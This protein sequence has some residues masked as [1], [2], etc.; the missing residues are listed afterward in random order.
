M[1]KKPGRAKR[2]FRLLFALAVVLG[3]LGYWANTQ[4]QPTAPAA[5][6]HI[7]YDD[8]KSLKAVLQH[9]QQKG[10]V[11][12]A[13][14]A[15]LY[16]R[17]AKTPRQVKRGTYSVKPG[18][19]VDE[20]FKS[21]QNPIRQMVR[22]PETYWAS[23][24][25]PLLEEKGV[26]KA[27][28]YMKWVHSPQ[29]FQDQVSFPLPKSGSLEGYLYPDT[30]DLPPLLGAKQTILRQLKAFEEKVYKKVPE[31]TDLRETLIV[32]SMVQLEVM[33]D[34]ERP[35]VAGVI[36]NRM[37]IKMPLQIDATIL[38][39]L[40]EWRKLTYKDYREVDS[41]YNT[42]RIK[43]LPPGPICSPSV[44]SVEA[45]LNP[46]SH[47]YLYYVALPEGRHMFSSTYDQ[48]LKNI[49]RRKAA[50]AQQAEK[51]SP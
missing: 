47:T 48:H 17:I 13:A 21:L 8:P 34:S 41:P 46:A 15:D 1:A 31:G 36:Q 27:E 42:Y 2:F 5:A 43:G 50:L 29:E 10:V 18:M 24:V 35:I 26:V 6:F 12:N 37:H 32:A 19:T 23:R 44:K 28:D 40:Q 14:V 30:Y 33:L 49:Q 11:R 51:A 16:S 45:A 7:R 9:L 22:I 25:A 20:L 38:Y 39:G 3:A 4:L